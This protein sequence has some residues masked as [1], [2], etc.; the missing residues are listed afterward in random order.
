MPAPRFSPLPAAVGRFVSRALAHFSSPV[1]GGATAAGGACV[2]VLGSV[3]PMD[4]GAAGTVAVLA[5]PVPPR[6]GKRLEAFGKAPRARG[7]HSFFQWGTTGSAGNPWK[8]GG[9]CAKSLILEAML[10]TS[11][12]RFSTG[13]AVFSTGHISAARR[14]PLSFSLSK[15]LKR[16]R[17]KQ[18]E[19]QAGHAQR[20]PRVGSV[21]PR[22]FASAYFF[23]HGF[24][25]SER[26]NPGKSVEDIP[27][28]IKCLRGG[29]GR[30]TDPQVALPVLPLRAEK[31]G[32][33]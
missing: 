30:S 6:Q 28:K 11:Y 1:C 25:R 23:I 7:A 27:L 18:G 24:H 31:Q 29:G 9:G 5:S 19:R 16:K 13:C 20:H 2:V 15:S 8:L 33:S 10:P 12:P 22:I 14:P 21:F 32:V 26:A 4:R 3:L 17:K